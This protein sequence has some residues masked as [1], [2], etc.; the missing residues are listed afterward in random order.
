MKKHYMIKK[1]ADIDEVF[2]YKRSTGDQYF[3]VYQMPHTQRHFKF[4]IS[5]GRK[6]GTAVA[7]NLMK[8]RVRM[9]VAQYKDN[10][11]TNVSFVVVVKVPSNELKFN[12]IEKQL[13]TLFQKSKILEKEA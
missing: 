5:I 12:E 2:S 10:I 7:R 13:L 11:K 9:I 3:V 6:Y 8:R 1:R 4:A